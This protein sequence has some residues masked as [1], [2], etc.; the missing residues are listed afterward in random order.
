M[1]TK[2]QF[3]QISDAAMREL[4]A[5]SPE[6]RQAAKE[7]WRKVCFETLKDELAG[8]AEAPM[9]SRLDVRATSAIQQQCRHLVEDH[10]ELERLMRVTSAP[11][12]Y[13]SELKQSLAQ[14]KLLYAQLPEFA[15][16]AG[17][18]TVATN[19]AGAVAWIE[20]G[21]YELLRRTVDH[22]FAIAMASKFSN[23]AARFKNAPAS[24]NSDAYWR[25]IIRTGGGA[26][27][28][29]SFAV[30]VAIADQLM[31]VSYAVQGRAT[32][33]DPFAAHTFLDILKTPRA[34]WTARYQPLVTALV[35]MPADQQSD[36]LATLAAQKLS[37]QR[38]FEFVLRTLNGSERQ[39]ALLEKQVSGLRRSLGKA[40]DRAVQLE[41]NNLALMAS[42]R[43]A[44]SK[45]AAHQ[46]PAEH[47]REVGAYEVALRDKETQLG[48]LRTS[49]ADTT[50]QLALTRE[51]LTVLL[52]PAPGVHA[53]PV[54]IG[55]ETRPEQ[56]RIIFVGGHERLHAKLR[57]QMRNSIFLHPD[58]SQ[59]SSE[60]FNHVDAVVF[61]IGYCSHALAYRAA[62]EVRRRGLRAG[63]SNSTNVEMVLDDVREIL[64]HEK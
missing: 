46:V 8:E 2:R 16:A 35:F 51:L 23:P 30:A 14:D 54:R 7:T 39:T 17:K 31:G 24:G 61:S 21:G 10:D 32:E 63:Y 60:A 25:P 29:L 19:A 44:S 28:F 42:L 6:A 4:E 49:L 22:M 26:R 64:F 38:T 58:Q 45:T 55:H 52:E 11:E 1:V 40:E 34:L 62:D 27:Y 47:A 20:A 5:R 15:W 56:W 48:R 57:K 59:F 43:T 18:Q 53:A 33:L 37:M 12:G 36:F 41:A 13:T 50:E 3:A 9:H